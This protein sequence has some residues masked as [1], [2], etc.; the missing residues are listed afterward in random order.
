MLVTSLVEAV[1]SFVAK[2]NCIIWRSKTCHPMIYNGKGYFCQNAGAFDQIL[3][4]DNGWEL[5]DSC[6]E[7]TEEEK[8]GF[9]KKCYRK[10]F[11]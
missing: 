3:G 11:L 9:C 6:F 7:K 10:K 2:K 1:I 5:T 8:D 4:E